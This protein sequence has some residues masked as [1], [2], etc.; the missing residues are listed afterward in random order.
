MSKKCTATK[1]DGEPCNAWAI[2]GGEVCYHHGGAA[3]Q[4]KR[5]AEERL[6]EAAG[7]AA[8]TLI[9]LKDALEDIIENEDLEPHEMKQIASEARKQATE[10]LDRAGPPKVKRQEMTGEDGEPMEHEID[11]SESIK[12]YAEM[13]EGEDE[14]EQ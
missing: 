9:D 3:P 6:A 5:K 4:V 8:K 7:G 12:K 11:T 10:I 2:E 1:K 13:F 14:S